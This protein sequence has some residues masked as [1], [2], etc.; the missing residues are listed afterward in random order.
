MYKRHQ[1]SRFF[2]LNT[3]RLCFS[4]VVFILNTDYYAQNQ[5]D[6]Q[7]DTIA[8]ITTH[9]RQ[10]I[11]GVLTAEDKY[12]IT[13]ETGSELRTFYKSNIYK[14]KYITREQIFDTNEFENPNPNYTHYCFMP[15]SFISEKGEFNTISH[16][17][18]TANSKVGLHE[19]VEF[20]IGNFLLFNLFSSLTF[21]KNIT[22]T[23]LGRRSITAAGSIM[24]N[25]LID[26]NNS[27]SNLVN[28]WGGNSRITIGNKNRN[29]TIGF[30]AYDINIKD[31]VLYIL[32]GIYFGGYFGSQVKLNERFTIAGESLGLTRDNVQYVFLNSVKVNWI[33]N[34]LED[35]SLGI[36]YTTN[37]VQIFENQD[38][39][40]PYVGFQRKF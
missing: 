34:S 17:F 24:G 23:F 1:K 12:S 38:R 13:I 33:R 40:L 9:D 21:S 2:Y 20:S 16:Y 18:V 35:W 5:V 4:L 7:S 32:S 39:V 27:S 14:I 3:I 22:N 29:S 15:S 28:G 25:Y 30:I 19:N 6:H 8:V 37:N 11:R 31:P 10:E 36:I 26:I